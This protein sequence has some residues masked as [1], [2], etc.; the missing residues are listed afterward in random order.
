MEIQTDTMTSTIRSAVVALTPVAR[1][2]AEAF[3]P[4]AHEC[5]RIGRSLLAA[6]LTID[7]DGRL[8]GPDGKLVA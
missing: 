7:S 5:L 1:K 8:R 4:I 3:Q 2:I 6:G